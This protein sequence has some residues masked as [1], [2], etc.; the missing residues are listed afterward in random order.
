MD[1]GLLTLYNLE[2]LVSNQKKIAIPCSQFFAVVSTQVCQDSNVNI[3]KKQRNRNTTT[4]T[5]SS[6]IQCLPI[7]GL[8]IIICP[9]AD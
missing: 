3:F 2:M 7:S 4:W 9:G 8:V 6:F 5:K 1:Q